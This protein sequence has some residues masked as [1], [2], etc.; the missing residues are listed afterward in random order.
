MTLKL[1]C[2][3]FST[4]TMKPNGISTEPTA[5]KSTNTSWK[6]S[7]VSNQDTTHFLRRKELPEKHSSNSILISQDSR[8][9]STKLELKDSNQLPSSRKTPASVSSNTD[10]K[11]AHQLTQKFQKT[12][13]QPAEEL[14]STG[15]ISS[16]N[17]RMSST[18]QL[19]QLLNS[20][21]ARL[22]NGFRDNLRPSCKV[23]PTTWTESN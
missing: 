12:Q 1:K 6:S 8:K 11:T 9:L 14:R 7:T 10:H 20:T 16:T 13:Q 15:K 4:N 22:S 2:Q 5:E 19:T 18:Y 23:T 21:K 3:T 17:L